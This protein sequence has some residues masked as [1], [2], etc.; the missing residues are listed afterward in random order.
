MMRNI[1]FISYD[2]KYPNLCK[3]KLTLKVE[4]DIVDFIDILETNGRSYFDNKWEP[5]IEKGQWYL[6]SDDIELNSFNFS[7]E[8][9][10]LIEKLINENVELGCCGGCL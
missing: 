9:I 1:Q 8:E 10:N 3:G 6:C 4:N 7:Y 2:G 5:H